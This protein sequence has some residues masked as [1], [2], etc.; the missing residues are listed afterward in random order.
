LCELI[1]KKLCELNDDYAVER[2][3]ALKN[4]FLRVL[5]TK[6]F[7]EWMKSKGKEGGQHKFPRVL[8]GKQLDDWDSFVKQNYEK[9]GA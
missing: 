9:V 3:H 8:K 1:D 6:A 7:Y 2:G 4:I 5:P